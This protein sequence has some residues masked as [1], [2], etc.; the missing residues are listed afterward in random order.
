MQSPRS[1]RPGL[2]AVWALWTTGM[3]VQLAPLVLGSGPQFGSMTVLFWLIVVAASL[4]VVSAGALLALGWRRNAPELGVVAG[5]FLAG[6]IL[7]LVHGITSP[8][9]LYGENT[10][11]TVSVF[12]TMPLAAALAL[13]SLFGRTPVGRFILQRWKRWVSG[14]LVIVVAVASALL[15][16]PNW[17][18][19]PRPGSALSVAVAL[20]MIA[21]TMAFAARHLR[22]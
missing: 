9:V 6:S 12:L 11:T 22:R 13:P 2:V 16:A 5:F 19:A 20:A 10:A 7:P 17:L 18:P 8:G 21:V 14:W 4:C 15:I 1:A 3:V